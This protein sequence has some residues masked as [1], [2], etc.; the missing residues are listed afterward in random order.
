MVTRSVERGRQAGKD[1]PNVAV[2]ASVAELEK[3]GVDAIVVSTPP[4]TRRELVLEAVR[5][6][7]NTVADKPFA[8]DAATA[9]ELAGEAAR[10]G[11][12]LN[13]FHNRRFDTDIV[14][15]QEV[16]RSGSVGEVRRLELRCDQD[17]ITSI[18]PGPT[19]GLLR[20]LGSH[21]VDQAIL[22]CGRP[23]RVVAHLDWRAL[24]TGRTDVGFVIGIEHAS[25]AYSTVSA[26][27][28]S[29]FMSRELRIHGILG[30]YRSDYSDVQ[31]NAVFD[32]RRPRDGRDAW[33]Y[34]SEDRWGI[35]VA[36]AGRATVPSRQGDYTRFYDALAAAI[37]TGGAGPV[38]A[39]EGIAVLE[40]LDAARL[41]DEE[42]RVVAL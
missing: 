16:I 10:A 7:L 42:H 34:E 5:A 11:V 30:S 13:V 8:P 22:L 23:H 18:E 32:G 39:S 6:G 1:Y 3:L 35:L 19:G 24:P 12:L 17:D 37:E 41:S 21:V 36:E 28:A 4:E 2:C 33:G 40:T 14:T 25:G 20:D 27:K 15:A 29:R 31:A 9:R 38:P 26:S